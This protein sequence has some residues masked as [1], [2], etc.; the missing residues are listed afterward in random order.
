MF[1]LKVQINDEAPI[2]VGAADLGVISASVAALGKLGPLSVPSRPMESE[3]FICQIGGLTAHGLD[4]E[5]KHLNW[6]GLQ[7]LKT[8]DKILIKIVETESV[9]PMVKS[10]PL[11]RTNNTNKSM[12]A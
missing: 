3:E 8:G 12:D 2:V 11:A 6:G 1:A 10:P 5:N 7:H 9:S 4:G